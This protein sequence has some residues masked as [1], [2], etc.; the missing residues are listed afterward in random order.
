MTVSTYKMVF[1]E[2]EENLDRVHLSL[3]KIPIL[4]QKK[5]EVY[6]RGAIMRASENL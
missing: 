3:F 2:K 6:R 1:R 5:V 4:L